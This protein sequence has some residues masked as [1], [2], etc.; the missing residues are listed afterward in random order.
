MSS[1]AVNATQQQEAGADDL[2]AYA[3]QIARRAA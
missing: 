1:T 2:R 3:E